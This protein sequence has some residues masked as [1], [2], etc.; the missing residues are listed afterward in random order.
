MATPQR[1][2]ASPEA[3]SS[4]AA[5]ASAASAAPPKRI[6][7]KTAHKYRLVHRS[8]EDPLI[9]DPE[10][11]TE[12]LLPLP[13]SHVQ[14][15]KDLQASGLSSVV[16]ENEG[17][18]ALY[19]IT[20][21]DSSY[22]YMQHL[23]EIGRNQD[24][25]AVFIPAAKSSSS[26]TAAGRRARG[27]A[28]KDDIQTSAP[29][30]TEDIAKQVLE[31]PSD[32]HVKRTYQD[33]QA[34]P[35]AI[36]GLQPDMDPDLREVL[37]AL[38]DEAYVE[39]DEDIF[40]AIVKDDPSLAKS[41]VADAYDDY[42]DEE[43]GAGWEKE[44]AKFKI[45]KNRAAADSSDDDF[46]EDEDLDDLGSLASFAHKLGVG[47]KSTRGGART[48]TTGFS[49]S[50]SAMFRNE[51]LT[52][53][54]DRFDQIEKLYAESDDDEEE[55]D[56]EDDAQDLINSLSI[57][58]QS[59]AFDAIMDDFLE[60]YNVVGKRLLR[61]APSSSTTTSSSS[62]S[63]LPPTAAAYGV[64]SG[65]PGVSRGKVNKWTGRGLDQLQE[66]KDELGKPRTQDLKKRYRLRD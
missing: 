31:L 44:F 33:Q 26:S 8:Q 22:D 17:E 48:S 40:Q 45:S 65:M 50:S 60:N 66:I 15:L 57:Q 42:N 39:D 30:A 34:I 35:D 59:A 2:A 19:G 9:Y 56:E 12:D 53:I 32:Q 16:R 55:E 18:A 36:A 46:D 51:G 61:E 5:A 43:E 58:M 23:R 27:I 29:A 13:S 3:A 14:T 25:T 54:D 21:D 41:T 20:Y 1:D 47:K 11:P 6:N 63:K 49:M 62:N 64:S 24:G 7:R 52:L 4:T 37:E 28:F 38:E 10:A